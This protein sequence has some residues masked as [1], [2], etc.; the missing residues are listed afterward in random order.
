M[1]GDAKIINRYKSIVK[2]MNQDCSGRA[3]CI[4]SNRAGRKI[5]PLLLLEYGGIGSWASVASASPGMK[6]VR[7][8]NLWVQTQTKS[9]THGIGPASSFGINSPGDSDA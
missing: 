4:V 7:N 2:D 1:R 3:S 8:W 5:W 9:E 6:F